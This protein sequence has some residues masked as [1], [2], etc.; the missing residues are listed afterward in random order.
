MELYNYQAKIVKVV[1]GDTFEFIVDLGLNVYRR[2]RI[3]LK[4]VDTP[5]LRS[6]NANERL[7]AREA[8][9]LA[10]QLLV[11]GKSVYIHT[12]KDKTGKY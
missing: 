3:R 2:M 4:K 10:R 6:R 7:H 9:L 12:D 1:D 11:P 5:E 8:T